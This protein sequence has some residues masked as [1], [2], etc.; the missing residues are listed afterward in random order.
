[1]GD[2]LTVLYSGMSSV[3]K[4]DGTTV[5]MPGM[6]IMS[7]CVEQYARSLATGC[8]TDPIG[9]VYGTYYHKP[10]DPN[11]SVDNTFT[12]GYSIQSLKEKDKAN[13]LRGTNYLQV[14]PDAVIKPLIDKIKTFFKSGCRNDYMYIPLSLVPLILYGVTREE[15][16][17]LSGHAN[18]ILIRRSKGTVMRIEPAN[19]DEANQV[20]DRMVDEGIIKF[21]NEIG[22]ANPTL[23]EINEVCPQSLT[24]DKNC[25]FWTMF[26]FKEILQN[27]F[28]KDPNQVIAELSARPEL[29]TIIE[30]FKKEL[31]TKIIPSQLSNIG[32]KR[33][34]EFDTM[35]KG[36]PLVRAP[37]TIGGK[38]GKLK[39]RFRKTKRKHGLYLRKTG[40]ATRSK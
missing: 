13:V 28:K 3:V 31:A 8:V 12:G 20:A 36:F 27:I 34:P 25:V 2:A 23:V 5:Q 18:G 39:H 6:T 37:P 11:L 32:I 33:W 19:L 17:N 10:G 40:K 38:N 4:T 24:K 29:P 26:I 35:I 30:N 9:M 22:L 7:K 1:M 15:A 21:V 16:A 14:F